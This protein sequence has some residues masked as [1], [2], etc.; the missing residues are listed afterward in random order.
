MKNDDLFKKRQELKNTIFNKEHKKPTVINLLLSLTMVITLGFSAFLIYDSFNH[1]NQLYIIINAILIFI[2]VLS[3]LIAF[4]RSYQYQKTRFVGITAFS[5]IL[6]MVFNVLVFTNILKLPSQTF[7]PNFKDKTLTEALKWAEKNE[8]KTD[9]SFE[10]SDLVKK[11]D[12]INQNKKAGTLTK[13]IKK[14]TFEVSNGPDYSKEVIISDMTDW[15]I[16]DAI[17]VIDKNKL[18]NV[19]VNF[20]ENEN[21]QRDKITNQNISGTIKRNDKLT[22]NVSLG[23]KENLK[24]VKMIDLKDMTLFKA[25]LFLNRNAIDYEIKYKFSNKIAK[26]NV[27]TSSIKKGTKVSQKDKVT[28]TVS[29]G[30][31]IIVPN[32]K[33]KKLSYVTNWIIKNNLKIN[34]SDRYDNKI[35]NNHVI[36]ATYKKGDVIEE[37][38]TVGIVVSK[39]KLKMP[40]FTSLQEFK[41]WAEKY[42]IKHEIKEEFNEEVKQG[43]IIKFSIKKGQM[44]NT[45][46]TIIVYVSKGK[47]IEVPN[48]IGMTKTEI[49]NSCNKLKLNCS[50]NYEYSAKD[51]EGTAINQSIKAKE[52]VKENDSIKI[53]LA[54]KNKNEVTKKTSNNSTSNKQNNSNNNQSQNTCETGTITIPPS[55]VSIG[56]PETTCSNVKATDSGKYINCVYVDS[57]RAKKGQILNMSELQGTQGNTCSKKSLQIRKND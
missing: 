37:E 38:T 53:T 49:Q 48:F 17:K 27:I 6:L 20:E 57:T 29:K 41:T 45:D 52:K 32:L 28:L 25:T 47:E 42:K 30:K 9:Q 8:I 26:G 1:I 54:T 15:D 19:Y 23:L 2:T 34:Y 50:F 21:I 11:Y 46:E 35:K 24:E 5:V 31:K 16:D 56:N 44:I 18:N 14:I 55:V 40:N 3:A 4:K 13:N 12:I 39:G 51:K 7:V 33:N 22:L 36:E 10:Y 43:E